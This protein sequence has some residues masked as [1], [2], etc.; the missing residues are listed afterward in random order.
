MLGLRSCGPTGL[1]T[2]GTRTY[3]PVVRYLLAYLAGLCLGVHNLG[4]H[5]LTFAHVRTYTHAG[6]LLRKP[7]LKC[8]RRSCNRRLHSL[9][10]I[11]TGA[12]N[13]RFNA[14]VSTGDI[15]DVRAHRG[16]RTHVRPC[17]RTGS[18]PV[19]YVPH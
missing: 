16:S 10:W 11:R 18:Q 6:C 15:E 19:E 5:I 1:Y 14:P 12:L 13:L 4:V 7:P 8:A 17:L 2:G 3:G 9:M